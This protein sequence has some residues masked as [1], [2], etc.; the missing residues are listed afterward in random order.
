MKISKFKWGI[1]VMIL[2]LSCGV[3]K[4]PPSEAE[5]A[6]LNE[7]VNKRD[8]TIESDWASGHYGYAAGYEFWFNVAR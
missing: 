1:V 3:S 4:N 6:T 8:F 5:L 2:F 7:L